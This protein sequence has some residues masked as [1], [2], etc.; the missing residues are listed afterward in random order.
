MA[1]HIHEQN[2]S[3]IIRKE[4]LSTSFEVF[5][6][7]PLT[8]VVMDC[9]GKLE[10]SFPG[11]AVEVDG[12]TMS[13][14]GFLEQVSSI[15][16]KLDVEVMKESI[17]TSSK[18]GTEHR[19]TREAAHPHY[20]SELFL[21]ILLGYGRRVDVRGIKKRIA[22][23]V[24]W[25]NALRPWRRSPAWLIARVLLQTTIHDIAQYKS[26]MLYLH[27]S[28]LAFYSQRE[29]DPELLFCMQGKTARRL[30]KLRTQTVPSFVKHAVATAVQ[31]TQNHLQSW[32]LKTQLK[33]EEARTTKW[34]PET[35]DFKADTRQP[36]A[37][38]KAHLQKVTNQRDSP[39]VIYT[40]TPPTPYRIRSS[41][42]EGYADGQLKR[43]VA[44]ADRLA[45]ADFECSVREHIDIWVQAQLTRGNVA[46]EAACGT[47]TSCFTQYD[48]AA[49]SIYAR[50]ALD[51]STFALTILELWVAIDRLVVSSIPLLARYSPELPDDCLH[52]LLLRTSSDISRAS[53]L[54]SYVRDRRAAAVFGVSIFTDQ[55]AATS[56]S[57]KY[58]QMS[59]P[60]QQ[61]KK[62][63][64]AD[65][66][67]ARRT[68]VECMNAMNAHYDKLHT[69]ALQLDH[70]DFWSHRKRRSVHNLD[71]QCQRCQV[72]YA[73]AS[74]M[75]E[76]H[77]WPLPTDPQEAMATVFELQVPLAFAI[78]RS[79]TFAIMAPIGTPGWPSDAEVYISL[80]RHPDLASRYGQFHSLGR[81]SIASDT[82]SMLQSHYAL[83]RAPAYEADV[84]VASTLHYR[85]YDTCGASWAAGPFSAFSMARYGTLT[86]P[87]ASIYGY[88]SYSVENTGHQTNDV[89]A[90]RSSCPKELTLQEH[91]AFGSLRSGG[92]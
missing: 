89:I 87:S 62:T 22:D 5:E 48:E 17:V 19:E 44:A 26:F 7:H 4:S 31:H 29:A 52:S 42:F 53:V 80:P 60:L 65:A 79:V 9:S 90:D 72:E 76:V 46:V 63:I 13:Q 92:R 8:S 71:G 12:S 28:L 47:I 57:V 33:C 64:E 51:L 69:H 30:D 86:L 36:L 25:N 88:L 49:R 2:S 34:A 74:M 11:S 35:L 75:I 82:K 81:I 68:K 38:S 56:F 40:D 84:C 66:R 85:L 41:Y 77:E 83:V 70:E 10:R 27:A 23:E 6:I 21:G 91:D 59:K 20:V 14:Y 54:E 67:E 50:D 58:F 16:S 32:W 45:L 3:I 15:L 61:L 37:T 78:W 1:L 39:P 24:L 18:G 55:I 43:A 73:A